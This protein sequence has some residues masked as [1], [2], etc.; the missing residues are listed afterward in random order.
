MGFQGVLF[1]AQQLM[2]R[3]KILEDT[4]LIPGLAQWVKDSAL[5]WLWCRLAATAPIRLPAWEPP[6]AVGEDLKSQN[7]Q[8]NKQQQQKPVG[9]WNYRCKLYIECIN[10]N[11]LLYSTGN[12]IQHLVINYN[13][14]EYKRMD[15]CA[16]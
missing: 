15:H 10:N 14:K 13:G 9:V 3:T 6:Y 5:L 11:V 2:N 16:V 8:T 4:G 1:V 12:F 7:K